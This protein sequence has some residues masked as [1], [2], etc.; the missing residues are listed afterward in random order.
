MRRIILTCMILV[1]SVSLAA[2]KTPPPDVE[3][4]MTA[5]DFMSSG[6]DKL[7]SE[8]RDH[9]SDWLERYRQGAVSG[10]A[11]VRK[12]SEMTEEEKIQHQEE[13]DAELVAKVLPSFRGW[14]GKTVFELDNGQVWRQR[15]SGTMKYSGSN[16]SV[17]ISRNFLGKYVMKHEESGRAIGVKRID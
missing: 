15:Q 17:V 4:L 1:F 16:S 8:E 12:P 2:D 3:N 9:L 6:L 5:E 14:S 10:P 7:S 13:T 11:V